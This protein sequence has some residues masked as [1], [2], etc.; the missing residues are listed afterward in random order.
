MLKEIHVKNGL[1]TQNF[2]YSDVSGFTLKEVPTYQPIG[3]NV[4]EE[5]L[6]A[7]R[8]ISEETLRVGDK[9]PEIDVRTPTD[10]ERL[11][12]RAIWE[13][14]RALRTM[15]R[16][17]Y[18]AGKPKKP[19]IRDKRTVRWQKVR[20]AERQKERVKARRTAENRQKYWHAK[21]VQGEYYAAKLRAEIQRVPWEITEEEWVDWGCEEAVGDLKEVAL[22]RYDS[23]LPWRVDN[24]MILDGTSKRV[25]WDSKEQEMIRMGYCL[26]D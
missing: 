1:D 24:L 21:L 16:L 4:G 3:D 7:F 23:K 8:G 19:K 15:K 20:S 9:V 26:E 14:K 17:E 11:R 13:K 22:R 12:L 10:S 5:L 18:L 2:L 6:G 25:V